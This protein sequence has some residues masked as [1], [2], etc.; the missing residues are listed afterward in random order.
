MKNLLRSI[1]AAALFSSALAVSANDRMPDTGIRL[2]PL[3]THIYKTRDAGNEPTESWVIWLLVET[4]TPRDVKVQSAKI[5]LLSGQEVM[6]T[7]SYGAA[8]VR[9]LTIKFPYKPKALDGSPSPSPIYWPQAIRLRC[10]EAAAAKIDGVRVTL[11]LDE[12]GKTVSAEGTSPVE[13]YEQKTALIYPFKGKGVVTNAGVTNGG[14]RNR[15]GQFALDGVGLDDGYGVNTPDGGKKSE[16]YAGWGRTIMAPAAGVVVE[17]RADR[18]DQPDPEN[19]DPKFFAPEFPNGGDP[20]NH[21]V[22]D[23]GNGEFS[24]LA[25]FQTGS[26]LVKLGDHVEQGQ[27]LGKLGSSGDTT[28]PHLH[29]QLQTGPDIGHPVVGRRALQV[30]QHRPAVPRARH[31]LRGEV[32][33]GIRR[34]LDRRAARTRRLPAILLGSAAT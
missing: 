28:T 10:T 15:S 3:P 13:N 12:E 24:M 30:H 6:R 26:L 33:A 25:H 11:G 29:Y 18:P 34:K 16:D 5:E 7:T 9:P 1:L 14:H 23:H 19:S 2:Q 32:T 22:I 20:G 8:G 21:V 27:P 31:I 4:K 17:V